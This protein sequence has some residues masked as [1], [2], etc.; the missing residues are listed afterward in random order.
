MASNNALTLKGSSPLGLNPYGTLQPPKQSNIGASLSLQG[1]TKPNSQSQNTALRPGQFGGQTQNPGMINVSTP[2]IINVGGKSQVM[3]GSPSVL[4][5]QQELNKLGAGLVED[6]IAGEKTKA[7]IAKYGSGTSTSGDQRDSKGLLV[8]PVG[9]KFDR[10]TGNPIVEQKPPAELTVR[11][12]IPGLLESGKQ[13]ENEK[14]M[15]ER[16]LGA[17]E[18]TDWEEQARNTPEVQKAIQALADFKQKAAQEFADISSSGMPME[19]QQGRKQAL[20][21]QFAQQEAALASAVSNALTSQGQQ[22]QAAGTQAGRGLTSAQGAYT[23]AQTQAQRGSSVASTALGAVAPI[24][25]VS[26]GT[27]DVQPGLMGSGSGTSDSSGLLRGSA[28]NLIPQYYNEYN[29]AQSVIDNISKNETLFSNLLAT[30]KVNPT[31]L[32]PINELLQKVGSLTSSADYAN[33]QNLLSSLR[34]N[35]AQLLASRGLT[36]TDA[37]NTAQGLLPDNASI[38]T[39]NSVLNTLKQEGQNYLSSKADQLKRAEETFK[40]GT[41]PDTSSPTTSGGGGFAEAW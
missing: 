5:Q 31:D 18:V 39:I 41:A 3:K 21:L 17:G 38:A 26:Q 25:G 6:G 10:N 36:P 33:F 11:G 32:T 19:F 23:G 30:A 8:N 34:A 15:Q 24:V 16:L 4:K 29:Q 27:R 12:Q 9:A 20:A 13:T 28:A 37:G 40:T 2:P 1:T 35:Y 14:A 22:L 7:A